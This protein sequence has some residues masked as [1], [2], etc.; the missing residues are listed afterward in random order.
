[1]PNKIYTAFETPI[2][3]QDSGGSAVITLQNLAAATGRISAR[4][5]RGAGSIATWYMCRAKIEKGI[6]SVVNEVV[7]VYVSTSDGTNPDG[8]VGTADAALTT[9]NASALPLI[10]P[11]LITST[12]TNTPFTSSAPVWIPTR[13]FSVGVMNSTTGLLRNTANSCVISFTPLVDELQ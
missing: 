8:N 2:T 6:A 11:L 1:M 12:A 4:F 3:F 7:A 9:A 10:I 13:Y 5:D